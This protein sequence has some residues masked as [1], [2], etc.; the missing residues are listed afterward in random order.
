MLW[1]LYTRALSP[2]LA[3]ISRDL[4]V[5]VA[6]AEKIGCIRNCFRCYQYYARA[7]VYS[8]VL[9]RYAEILRLER[10]KGPREREPARDAET[11]E[12]S[13]ILLHSACLGVSRRKLDYWNRHISWPI[14]ILIWT[15]ENLLFERD[16]QLL[17]CIAL[18]NN[19]V[20]RRSP[21]TRRMK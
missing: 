4:S 21:L 17:V 1:R 13:C 10:K 11:S 15:S 12:L 7:K 6:Y 14:N 16:S 2:S 20:K 19:F 3:Q 8:D 5:T 18:I 9:A